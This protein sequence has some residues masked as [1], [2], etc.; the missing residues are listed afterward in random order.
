MTKRDVTITASTKRT[1][2]V[3]FLLL[4]SLM[5]IVTVALVFAVCVA[6]ITLLSM[7][8]RQQQQQ[9]FCYF[10]T[11]LNYLYILFYNTRAMYES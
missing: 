7:H 8:V 5:T 11:I 3:I 2:A 4:L 1:F 9:T 10:Y 6:D